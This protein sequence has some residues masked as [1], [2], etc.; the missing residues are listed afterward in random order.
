MTN[1]I[2]RLTIRDENGAYDGRIFEGSGQGAIPLN[3]ERD[4]WSTNQLQ[5]SDE[6]VVGRSREMRGPITRNLSLHE[7]S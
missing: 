4:E 6:F 3:L 2:N 5:Q 1:S 7:G